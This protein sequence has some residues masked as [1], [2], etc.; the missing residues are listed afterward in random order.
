MG[1]FY[2][3]IIGECNGK[4]GGIVIRSMN[5]KKFYSVRPSRYRKSV[6]PSALRTR[7][8]FS[9]AARLAKFII[10]IPTLCSIWKASSITGVSLYHKILKTNINRVKE[11]LLSEN[12][13]VFPPSLYWLELNTSI[14]DNNCKVTFGKA[15]STMLRLFSKELILHLIFILFSK[16][17]NNEDYYSLN[18]YC[19]KTNDISFEHGSELLISL[20]DKL[21]QEIISAHKRVLFLTCISIDENDSPVAWTSSPSI[22]F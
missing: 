16:D 2:S 15:E 7:N 5:H 10:R 17:Q 13:I 20:P 3:G 8:N 4:V 1:R 18:K 19:I 14:V 12:C 22:I 21:L 6:D 9:A 11:G